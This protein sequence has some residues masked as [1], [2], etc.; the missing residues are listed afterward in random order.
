VNAPAEL[1]EARRRAAQRRAAGVADD[2][3]PARL[4]LAR[5]RAA[6]PRTRLGALVGVT[7]SAITQFEKGQSKPTLPVLHLLAESLDV[8][9]EFFR[10]G[11]ALPNL[12]ASGAHFRS[13]R[14]TTALQREQAL[15]FGE[16]T[17]AVVAALEDHVQLPAVSLPEFDVP[18]ELAPSDVARLAQQ[19]RD[20]LGVPR[21]PIPHVVRLLE[22][23]GV[24]VIRLDVVTQN[25]DAFSHQ[26]G[27][28]PLV[29]LNPAK[30]DKAR[31][32]F[33]AAHELGH[34][35]MHHDAEPGSRL[36]E[37]QAHQFAAEFLAPAAEIVDDLPHRLDWPTLHRLK[38]RWGISLKA[39]VM[40]AHA[41]GR[42]TDGTYR[43]GMQQLAVAGLPERGSLGPAET[44]VLL[45][46]ALHLIGPSEQHGLRAL[47]DGAGLAVE[48]VERI[49]RAAGG[50]TGRP[51][52]SL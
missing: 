9:I 14:S 34:L 45:P 26:Q 17:L 39:L 8:S 5:R 4:A 49:Y 27:H 41:L 20:Q 24:V 12:P 42:I 2:F 19:A 52:L 25:V 3:D 21:G 47:A 32:R 11:R 33:D 36:V 48:E 23:H 40:R 46:R 6:L 15:A 18:A 1:H 43:R 31:S 44:P 29:M 38:R 35:L 16:L 13:L 51:V 30:Q 22:A 37:R 10:A 50:D 28:R 7:P